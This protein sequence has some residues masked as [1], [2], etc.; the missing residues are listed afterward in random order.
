MH[1][2]NHEHPRRHRMPEPQVSHEGDLK[3]LPYA[4]TAAKAA[5]GLTRV[6]I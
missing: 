1:D 4:A 3:G 6:T 5:G 2:K